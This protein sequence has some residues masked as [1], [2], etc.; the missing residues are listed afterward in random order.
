MVCWIAWTPSLFADAPT[1]PAA[2]SDPWAASRLVMGRGLLRDGHPDHAV[3]IF[4]SLAEL[5]DERNVGMEARYLLGQTFMQLDRREEALEAFRHFL[6]RD[7]K[8]A[9]SRLLTIARND[10]RRMTEEAPHWKAWTQYRSLIDGIRPLDHEARI[11][12]LE[13]F[14]SGILPSQVERAARLA[15]VQEAWEVEDWDRVLMELEDSSLVL[16]DPALVTVIEQARKERRRTRLAWGAVLVCCFGAAGV[17]FLR[18]WHLL[19]G[20][21]RRWVIVLFVNWGILACMIYGAYILGRQRGDVAPVTIG[22][23]A[24]LLLAVSLSMA[25]AIGWC[26]ILRE[27]LVRRPVTLLTL[28]SL[29]LGSLFCGC[30]IYLFAFYFDYTSVLG[31]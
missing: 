26:L 2:A 10:V 3:E 1:P 19:S 4:E 14:A 12:R 24:S 8:K 7:G 21:A 11:G 15:I 29:G 20:R 23:F 13:D 22:R 6:A 9:P 27:R 28:T 31:L 16:A 30:A 18:P 5:D 25:A 17:L